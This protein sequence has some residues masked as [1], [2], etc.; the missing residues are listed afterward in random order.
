M[1][2]TEIKLQKAEGQVA[3]AKEWMKEVGTLKEDI[4]KMK[5]TAVINTQAEGN[6]ANQESLLIENEILKS[7]IMELESSVN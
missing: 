5:Q 7:K 3:R 1:K 4:V 2:T 6:A